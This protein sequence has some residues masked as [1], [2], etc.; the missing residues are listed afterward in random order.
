MDCTKCGKP[1]ED[2]FRRC[3]RCRKSRAM[4]MRKYRLRHPGEN[5]RYVRVWQKRHP[6]RKNEHE[7]RRRARR[8][9]NACVIF[10]VS[11]W[12][13][14]LKLYNGSCAYCITSKANEMDHVVPLALGGAHSL[15]NVRPACS[16]CNRIKGARIWYLDGMIEA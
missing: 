8:R 10:S 14:K 1:S 6:E 5:T 15:A 3:S 7:H 13:E 9:G 11:D 16:S 2:G 12:R 4:S